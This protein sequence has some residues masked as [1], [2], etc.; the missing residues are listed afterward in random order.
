M[1]GMLLKYWYGRIAYT[2]L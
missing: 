2:V 1:F